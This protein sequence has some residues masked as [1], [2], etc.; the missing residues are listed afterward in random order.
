MGKIYTSGNW[1]LDAESRQLSCLSAD[2]H[3]NTENVTLEPRVV[4]L[5][6]HFLENPKRTIDRDELIDKVWDGVNV[7]ESAINWTIAQLRKSLSDN[8]APRRYIQTLSKKGYQWRQDVDTYSTSGNIIIGQKQHNDIRVNPTYSISDQPGYWKNIILLVGISLFVLIVVILLT[9]SN[10]EI[11]VPQTEFARPFTTLPGR[12]NQPTFSP[13]GRWLI[14]VHQES[15]TRR[16]RLMLK[17]IKEDV[18]FII[19]DNDNKANAISQPSFRLV[20]EKQLT[21]TASYIRSPSWAPHSKKLVYVRL[22]KSLCE[23]R[24]MTLTSVMDVGSE[25]TIFR[26]NDAGHSQTSWGGESNAF[27]FTDSQ[28]G[29]PYQIYRYDLISK[30]TEQIG[31]RE[32]VHSGSHLVRVSR[33]EMRAIVVRDIESRL[34]EF[35]LLDL[36]TGLE[37]KL[38][39]RK[40]T[41][42]DID[43][44]ADGTGFYFNQG[45]Q[46]LYRFDIKTKE[47]TLF[48]SGGNSEVYGVVQ[49]P[50]QSLFAYVNRSVDRSRINAVNLDNSSQA[51][52]VYSIDSSYQEWSPRVSESSGVVYFLSNRSGLPQIWQSDNGTNPS[53]LSN[54]TDYFQ[55]GDLQLSHSENE[56]IGESD[57]RVHSIN[58][59]NES[60]WVHSATDAKTANPIF[61]QNDRNIVFS[62]L[63]EGIWQLVIVPYDDKIIDPAVLTENGGYFSHYAGED[64]VY[65]AKKE[66][67]GLWSLNL[68]NRQVTVLSEDICIGSNSLDL[69]S[70]Y[71]YFEET[72][73]LP[74]GIYRWHVKTKE[75]ELI[76]D[77]EKNPGRGFSINRKKNQLIV[78]QLNAIESD[79]FMVNN[80]PDG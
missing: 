68:I 27:Y 22:D 63:I 44:D 52:V 76:Y 6:V 11:R 46:R 66:V 77:R 8:Q 54:L 15:D 32:L 16:S 20:P 18:D 47:I 38:F 40:G 75:L 17:A 7:S 60:S 42:Y 55:F 31:S 43:W 39:V 2:D 71:L 13:D 37:E 61:V 45:M 48:L 67:C 36:K 25:E 5:L 21:R 53:Q 35:Y 12:E 56:L 3:T 59:T 30:K 23:I 34:S 50:D 9:R 49:S 24:L 69:V 10:Q 57:F 19:Y 79:I 65:F 29:S 72:Q 33:K 58:I 73:L 41:Y 64:I 78:H 1:S 62:Q 80:K 4:A 51:T 26:C 28:H 14:F 70:D 74:N